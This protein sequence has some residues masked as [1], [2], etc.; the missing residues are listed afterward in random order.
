MKTLSIFSTIV[1]S[2]L[3]GCSARYAIMTAPAVSMTQPSFQPGHQDTA[4]GHV[5]AEYCQGDEPV[6]S[7]DR[8]VGLIDEAVLKAQ[9]QSKADYLSDVTIWADGDCIAVEGTAMK[10]TSAEPQQ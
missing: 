10:V 4:G 8:N 7:K 3:A 5:D 1:L 6:S 2:A 9:Q